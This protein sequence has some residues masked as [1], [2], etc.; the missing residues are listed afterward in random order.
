M[1][2]YYYTAAF[3]HNQIS[4]LALHHHLVTVT[5][6]YF[7]PHLS[8]AHYP[9]NESLSLSIPHLSLLTISQSS[10]YISTAHLSLLSLNHCHYPHLTSHPPIF[11]PHIPST[12]LHAAPLNHSQPGP[13]P[14][15]IL[16]G[17]VSALPPSGRPGR[18]I[19]GGQRRRT[20]KGACLPLG[21]SLSAIGVA[22]RMGIGAWGHMCVAC[23]LSLC[24]NSVVQA[25]QTIDIL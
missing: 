7:Y 18:A 15:A 9:F 10:H 23:V 5:I 14:E 2:H 22:G 3:F 20:L 1:Y 11:P 17:C 16:F 13:L 4:P 19:E 12:C 24:L 25:G 8:N 6:L 21:A